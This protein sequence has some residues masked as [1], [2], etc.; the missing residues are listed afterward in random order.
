MP[1]KLG[2]DNL[3]KVLV[4]TISLMNKLD[5]VTQDG[6][7]LVPDSIALF[8]NLVDVIGVIKN[9]KTAYLE[10]LDLDED[11]KGEV[12][13]TVK[14]KF[15]LLDDKLEDVVEKAFVLIEDAA[16]LIFAVQDALKKE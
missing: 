7:Q 15:D 16:V 4:A 1:E 10:F 8:P 12:Y 5:E 11:E 13:A 3:T 6:Y 9:G 14:A 2:V